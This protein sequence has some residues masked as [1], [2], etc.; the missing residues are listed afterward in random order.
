MRTLFILLKKELKGYFQ[1]PFG[2]VVLAV[3]IGMQGFALSTAMKG[4][5]DTP[6]QQSLVYVA[7]ASPVFWFMFLFIFPLITMRLFAEEERSGTLEGLL[8]APVRS[9]QVVFSKYG[10]AMSFYVILWAPSYVQFRMYEWVTGVPPAYA[11]GA[12]FGAYL[13]LFLMG[14][15]FTAIGCLASS[16]TSSQIIAGLVTI[17]LLLIQYFLGFVT[18]IWGNEFPGAPLFDYISSQRHLHYFSSGLLDSRPVVYYLSMAV[19]I[20]FLTY[21]V[22]DFRRWRR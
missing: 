6:S 1:S 9:W 21:H 2:W 11:P 8:T 4:F 22:V 14:S 19:F 3:V 5:R 15:A 12:M 10:A 18:L 16:L 13:I 20:L 17:G 7:F